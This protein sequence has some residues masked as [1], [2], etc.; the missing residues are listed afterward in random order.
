MPSSPSLPARLA[1]AFRRLPFVPDAA[2]VVAVVE[3]EGVITAGARPG[4]G[5]DAASV[6]K[7][8]RKAFGAK[9]KLV[10]VAVNSPGGAPAQSRMIHD[11][12][13][14]LAARHEVPVMSYIGDV[15]AS[16]GYMI[17]LSGDEIMAD[18]FAIVGS[19]GVI[20]AGFGFQDAIGKLGIERRVHTA[21]ENK[22]QLDPFRAEE[23]DDVARLED[24]LTKSHA[25]FRALVQ[26]R[27]GERL[28]S[29][30]LLD[31]RYWIAGDAAAHGL[32][33][34]I[35]DL[36]TILKDRY[37][38]EVRLKTYRA[39]DGGLVSRLLSGRV[40]AHATLAEE[41]LAA[42]EAR[43]MWGRFGL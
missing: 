11:R 7:P 21:G 8:L 25:L 16:G 23:P 5:L 2:P 43:G 29:D 37:G 20:S 15:G 31:G 22:S 28:A 33:D 4:R 19:V 39:K 32:I 41:A 26:D 38:D 13:R 9:P 42:V 40:G 10:V 36:R 34:G 12:V 14:G 6:D 17:A 1:A 3:M 30:D 27:R 24:L 18:P 35:G